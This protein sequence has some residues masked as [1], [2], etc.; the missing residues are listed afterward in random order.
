M[1]KYNEMNLAS[2]V[3]VVTGATSGIGKALT[4][5]LIDEGA[6]LVLTGRR[7]GRLKELAAGRENVIYV[8]GDIADIETS[9]KVTR[10]AVERFG[11]V[12]SLVCAAGIGVYGDLLD[13]TDEDIKNMVETNFTGTVHG[14]RAVLPTMLENK[15]G[16]IVIVSSVAGVRG[17]GNEAVYAGTKAAQLIFAGAVDR[18]VREKGVRVTSICPAATKT[19]FA[20]GS[21]R[22]EG[23]AWLENVIQP[24]D[25]AAAIVFTLKQPRYLRTTRWEIWAMS[26][27]S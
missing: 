1:G 14:V 12:D 11:R 15:S 3:V 26:E 8:A 6:N 25:I 16:D 4:E 10:T 17:G 23:D 21:G 20:I 18:E 22:T 19:E 5:Q 13:N 7:E 9:Q 24:E 2:R 27:A